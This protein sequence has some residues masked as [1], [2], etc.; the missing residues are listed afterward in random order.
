MKYKIRDKSDIEDRKQQLKENEQ[1]NYEYNQ[2]L[3]TLNEKIISTKAEIWNSEKVFKKE[4]ELDK[5]E[6]KI[7]H[8][9]NTQK[10][11]VAFFEQN[12]NCPT[13][14]QPIDLRF[15]QTQVYEGKKKISELEDNF[16]KLT[17][18]DGE[19]TRTNKTI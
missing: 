15:K 10:K 9:L 18:R 5:L 16:N 3:Q 4:K 11:D 17:V 7:E 13:C 12:D 1:S 19:N 6:S 2:K 8:K 14:T